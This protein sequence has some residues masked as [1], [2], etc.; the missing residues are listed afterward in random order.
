MPIKGLSC[1]AAQ[2]GLSKSTRHTTFAS[3]SSSAASNFLKL[4]AGVSWYVVARG[5]R[6]R[7]ENF[8]V[9]CKIHT[10]VLS[11]RVFVIHYIKQLALSA[12]LFIFSLTHTREEHFCGMAFCR[13]AKFN[14]KF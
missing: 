9:L 7:L 5:R 6:P 8:G 12:E 11:R 14:Q 4:P 3:S 10:A 2:A 1:A 13:A